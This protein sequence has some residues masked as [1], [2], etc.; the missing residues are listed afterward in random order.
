MLQV[1]KKVLVFCM[2]MMTL[3]SYKMVIPKYL[4]KRFR[5][6]LIGQLIG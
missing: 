1:E 3:I 5:E 2:Q 6:R 4:K